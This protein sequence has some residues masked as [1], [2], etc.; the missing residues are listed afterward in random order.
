MAKSLTHW[1]AAKKTL[2][3]RYL[4][5]I[6]EQDCGTSAMQP[7][8]PDII[9]YRSYELAV[10]EPH[11]LY[12]EECGDPD[13]IPVL[14]VHGG[15]GSGC[16]KRDRRFFDPER[17]RIILFDQRGAGRSTPHSELR[18]NT[19]Q[20]LIEDM[21][22]IRQHLGLDKWLLFGGSWGAGLALLYAEAHP[23]QVSGMILRGVFLCRPQDLQWFY[24]EGGASRV[25]PDFWEDFVGPI[26]VEERQDLIKA[27]HQRL[28]GANE[29]A[30]MGAAKA[31][32]TWEGRCATLRANNEVVDTFSEP[33]KA[34]GLSCLETHYFINDGFVE[35]D[36]II[37]NAHRL[38][39]IPG[40]IVHG[41]YD[42]VCPVDN[43]LALHNAWPDSD[44]QIIRDAGHSSTEMPI[45]DALIRATHA[46]AELV[47]GEPDPSG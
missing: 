39:G 40:I 20:K 26:P 46:M 43:A 7:L 2:A 8:F 36:Q 44:L 15:P 10:E 28:T 18:N 45:I 4:Q 27:Y 17:Y 21:E 42:M 33:H 29:L 38:E 14:F 6:P 9:P 25:F 30:K 16:S 19:T 37:R 32:A 24:H 22:V 12:V 41:R 5:L 47:T 23:E 13:G 1:M 11:K 3:S 31:W 34:L 35:P